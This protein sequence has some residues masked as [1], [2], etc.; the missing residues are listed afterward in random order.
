MTRASDIARR[1]TG[2]RSTLRILIDITHPAHLHFFKHPIQ[3]LHRRGHTLTLTARHKDILAELAAALPVEAEFIGASPSGLAGLSR[4]L[5][6]RKRV[7]GRIIDRFQPDVLA[8]VGG[9]FIGLLGWLKAVPNV[10]FYD[11]ESARISN[12]MTYRFASRICTPQSYRD[13]LPRQVRYAGYQ[14]LAYLAPNVFTPDPAVRAD[15]D[16]GPQEPYAIV[17]F[18]GWQAGHD[19]GRRG[20]NTARKIE[21]ISRLVRAGRVFVS[22]EGP[23]PDALE[24][25]R[26]PLPP[27]RMHDALAEASLLFGESSTMASEAAVLGVPSVFVYPEVKLGYCREQATR[28]QIVHWFT[29]DRFS[30]A[31]DRAEQILRENQ[32]SHWRGIGR[33]IVAESIDV[34]AFVCDQIEQVAR[35]RRGAGSRQHLGPGSRV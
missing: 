12:H 5:V 33:S 27:A 25:H 8:A 34:S 18:V 16:L 22:S 26:F 15:L 20:L 31:L 28:W 23:L 17:R 3:T 35:T 24:P 14:E 7:L 29:P 6:H 30:A 4:T 2:D 19:L 21:A 32:R 10:I 9:T 13:H 11:T 1:S